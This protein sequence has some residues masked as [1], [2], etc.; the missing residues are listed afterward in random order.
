MT[1][2]MN[3]RTG[4]RRSPNATPKARTGAGC[5][6]RL[7]MVLERFQFKPVHSFPSPTCGRG[8]FCIH[9]NQNR[10][11]L[12]ELALAQKAGKGLSRV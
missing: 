10:S 9:L 7:D 11:S 8:E 6:R 4:I 2:T 12:L 5:V 1:V 3:S